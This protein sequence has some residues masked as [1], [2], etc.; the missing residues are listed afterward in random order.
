MKLFLG[1]APCLCREVGR[2]EGLL[3]GKNQMLQRIL[4]EPVESDE[5]LLAQTTEQLANKLDE[6]HRRFETGSSANGPL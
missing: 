1:I 3:A 5:V 6:L 2:E 4:L